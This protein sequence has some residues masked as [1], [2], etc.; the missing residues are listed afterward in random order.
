MIDSPCIDVC[1]ID[2]KGNFCL[3]CGR[4]LDEITNWPSYTEE[5]KKM[6]LKRLKDRS[7]ID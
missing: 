3:G 4:V 5:K 7:N 6:V 2:P 1:K